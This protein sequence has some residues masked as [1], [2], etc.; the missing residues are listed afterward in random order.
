[1]L[2]PRSLET[3]VDQLEKAPPHVGFIYPNIRHF[4]NRHDYYGAPEY[5]LD[6]LLAD[7]YCAA[8]TLFDRRVFDAG[9]RYAEDIVHGH[10]DWDLVLQMAEHRIYGEPAEGPT[11]MYRKQGFS[12]VNTV[13]Y[14][15]DS[16]HERI[17]RRH[18]TLY[19]VKRDAIKAEWAPALSLVLVDRCDGSTSCWPT[20]LAE[21]LAAQTCCDF[22]TISANVAPDPIERVR[23]TGCDGTLQERVESAVLAARGRFVVL[24]G[25]QAA[26]GVARPTFIEQIIR[27]FYSNER[28]MRFVV[29]YTEDKRRPT[30][31]PLGSADLDGA[32]PCGVAWRRRPEGGSAKV[33]L[34]VAGTP[35]EDFILYWQSFC[36]VGWRAI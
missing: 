4:G 21:Y 7:N 27:L 19:R 3:M 12:R 5:N 16:F 31:A 22:E 10:E 13:Q 28:L 23:A 18:P 29:A 2:L 8:A 34:G 1:M 9:I 26:A 30:L 15:P 17:A 24:V 14:G 25:A 20:D 32:H 35:V 36:K 6:A 11:L 33:D